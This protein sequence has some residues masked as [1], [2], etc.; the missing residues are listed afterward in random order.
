MYNK[1]HDQVKLRLNPSC[2]TCWGSVWAPHAGRWTVSSQFQFRNVCCCT[3]QFRISEAVEKFANYMFVCLIFFVFCIFISIFFF[4][5]DVRKCHLVLNVVCFLLG[6]S[7]AS[8][9]YVLMFQNTLF[10]LHRQVGVKYWGYTAKFEILAVQ[11]LEILV[12]ICGVGR[13][14]F[15]VAVKAAHKRSILGQ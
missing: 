10:H 7:P 8:E 12:N 5:S 1:L 3:K 6:N 4:N 14:N 2:V 11:C 15:F 13:V 9:F